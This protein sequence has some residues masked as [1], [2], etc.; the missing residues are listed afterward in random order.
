[1]TAE[2]VSEEHRSPITLWEIETGLRDLI[3]L[4]DVSSDEDAEIQKEVSRLL[5]QK[6]A[7]VDAIGHVL[8]KL[9]NEAEACKRFAQEQ[10]DRAGRFQNAAERLKRY[11]MMFLQET[12]TKKLTGTH[13]TMWG[14][15]APMHVQIDD[16]YKIP[17]LFLVEQEPKPDI[18]RIRKMLAVESVPGARLVP[19]APYLRVKS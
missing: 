3:E 15:A 9:E 19:G 10:R 6:D 17:A 14:C 12:G 1:M 18:A 11:V 13:F 16:V 5:A 4:I 2:H 8:R 7:K